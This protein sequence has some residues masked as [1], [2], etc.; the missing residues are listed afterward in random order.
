MNGKTMK[1]N[2]AHKKWVSYFVQY[3]KVLKKNHHLIEPG[4]KLFFEKPNIL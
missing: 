4:L 1:L 2:I 3:F